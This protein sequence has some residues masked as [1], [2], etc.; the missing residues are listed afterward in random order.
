MKAQRHSDTSLAAAKAI[1]P[2]SAALRAAVLNVIAARGSAT[3]E[4]IQIELGIPGDT[5]RPR[6]V[7]LCEVGRV[8]DSGL[9]R[10]T[11]R[12]RL[13]AVWIIK[14]EWWG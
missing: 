13:A 10:R 8:V 2:N 3:D 1:K 9:R 6:R 7:E 5:Q 14:P 11:K 12:G 4:E